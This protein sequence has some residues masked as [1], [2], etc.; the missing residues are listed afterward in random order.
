MLPLPLAKRKCALRSLQPVV[1][2]GRSQFLH[3]TLLSELSNSRLCSIDKIVATSFCDAIHWE[4]EGRGRACRLCVCDAVEARNCV[5]V[6][7]DKKFLSR[8]Q[9]LVII[10]LQDVST[11]RSLSTAYRMTKTL[12]S[13]RLAVDLSLTVVSCSRI[14]YHCVSGKHS[15]SV[16]VCVG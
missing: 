5:D 11:Q 16:Y 15:V 1:E 7:T 6:S 10:Q 3:H 2:L 13:K 4:G 9:L 14:S 8:T 12:W